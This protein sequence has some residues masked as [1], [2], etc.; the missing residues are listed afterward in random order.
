MFNSFSQNMS[1]KPD[2]FT[3]RS[4]S[5]STLLSVPGTD[6]A[7]RN[8]FSSVTKFAS[9]FLAMDLPINILLLNAGMFPANN[10][11]KPTYTVS[12]P[13]PT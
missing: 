3:L 2:Q 6:K 11:K 12:P 8:Q 1:V 7:M 13:F 5:G 9:D 4:P 10:Q